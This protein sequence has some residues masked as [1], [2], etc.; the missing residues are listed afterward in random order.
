MSCGCV[1]AFM[2]LTQQQRLFST[3]AKGNH[4][5]YTVFRVP[6]DSVFHAGGRTEAGNWVTA[7]GAQGVIHVITGYVAKGW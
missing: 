1:S 6:A 2:T 4:W 5:V 3:Q 7:L